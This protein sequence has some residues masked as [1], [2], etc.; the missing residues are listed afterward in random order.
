MA[1]GSSQDVD[2][3]GGNVSSER[4]VEDEPEFET[5]YTKYRSM[6]RKLVRE[7][8]RHSLGG[9]DRDHGD[10]EVDGE[11]SENSVKDQTYLGMSRIEVKSFTTLEDAA[12]A[13]SEESM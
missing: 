1:T 7:E 10:P 4:I 11:V 3:D 5:I 13:H 8:F 2:D 12:C 9:P 6:F